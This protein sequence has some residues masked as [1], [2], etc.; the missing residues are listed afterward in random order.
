MLVENLHFEFIKLREIIQNWL[1]D[2]M[3]IRFRRTC[4]K[5]ISY[6]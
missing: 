1:K 2:W 6:K 5:N 3:R 4:I